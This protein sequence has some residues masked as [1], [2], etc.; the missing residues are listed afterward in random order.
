MLPELNISIQR[1]RSDSPVTRRRLCT[2]VLGE[3][4]PAVELA[5]VVDHAG[6]AGDRRGSAVRQRAANRLVLGLLRWA[7]HAVELRST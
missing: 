6:L 7:V 1:L 4:R 5:L 3:V 2:L